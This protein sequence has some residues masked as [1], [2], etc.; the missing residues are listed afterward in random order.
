MT[1]VRYAVGGGAP[2]AF[3]FTIDN[4]SFLTALSALGA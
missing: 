2:N 1:I 3:S 4:P